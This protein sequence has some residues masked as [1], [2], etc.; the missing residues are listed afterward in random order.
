MSEVKVDKISPKT[1]TSMTVGDSGDTFTVPSGATLTVA[2]ALNVTGTTSLADG[3]VAVAELD[4]DGATDIG[5]GIADADLLV[6]DDGAGGT[7]RKTAASRLKTFILA[8]NSIDSDMYV[9]GSIDAAHMSAN[10]IDSD[11]YVDGSIDTAHIADDQ[12]T[13][14]KMAGGTDGNVIS[15]DSSGDPVAIATGN[16]GQVLTSAGSGQPPAFETLPAG[17]DVSSITGA[18]ADTTVP[19]TTDEHIM[20]VGGALRRVDHNI[21]SAVNTPWLQARGLTGNQ[22]IP[23]DTNTIITNWA[24]ITINSKQDSG[25]ASQSLS[26]NGQFTLGVAGYYQINLTV[27]LASVSSGKNIRILIYSPHDDVSYVLNGHMTAA[28]TASY[29]LSGSIVLPAGSSRYFAPYVYHNHGSNI[30]IESATCAFSVYRIA[31]Y[32]TP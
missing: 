26:S 29:R 11:S 3:T 4:I 13:L 25:T 5:A 19:I 15:Y 14:A 22:S 1:G 21:V 31:G 7:N 28:S 17:F 27:T 23:N 9:D 8:D 12:I 32:D 20:N 2:G 10:S 30:N 18:T 16:D 6:I 24:N